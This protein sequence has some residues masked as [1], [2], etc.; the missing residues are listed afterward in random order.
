MLS[1]ATRSSCGIGSWGRLVIFGPDGS[2]ER[3]VGL[4]PPIANPTG[5]VGVLG[6][7]GIA[8]GSHDVQPFDT[9]LTPQFLQ[10]LLYDWSG[11]LLDTLV[12]LPYGERGLV[13]GSSMMGSPLFESRG[14][15][16]TR[17]DLLYTSDGSSPEVRVHRGEQLES[18]VH[19]EPGD[20]S[21]RK[22]DVE[23]YRALRLER[24]GDWA[25]LLRKRL[26]AFP[27][28]DAFPAVMEIQVDDE[29]RIW[30]RT[31]AR[32]GS[33]ATEWLGFTDSGAFICSLSIPRA[34]RVFHFDPSE[35]VAV[36]QDEMG[37]ESIEVRTIHFPKS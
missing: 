34:S 30:I 15:F 22:E 33:T 1:L 6:R 16:S 36:R 19:W 26:D 29:G 23:A 28:K 10:I 35:V 20:L 21:V 5:T 37:V 8:L 7:A 4:Q 18:M 3:S 17:G 27:V 31:F 24:A 32:P 14:I 9:R 25:P 11:R 12:T 13:Q 2:H